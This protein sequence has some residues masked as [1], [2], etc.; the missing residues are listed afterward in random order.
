MPL[1][2]PLRLSDYICTSGLSVWKDK[3]C[4][5]F[6]FHAYSLGTAPANPSLICKN[7]FCSFYASPKRVT[8]PKPAPPSL[9]RYHVHP[10]TICK[11][12]LSGSEFYSEIQVR[13]PPH[14]PRLPHRQ[15]E[16]SAPPLHR[17]QN[18]PEIPKQIRNSLGRACGSSPRNTQVLCRSIIAR[19]GI[20][21]P[22]PRPRFLAEIRQEKR[23]NGKSRDMRVLFSCSG[24]VFYP[25]SIA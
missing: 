20:Q 7:C 3:S 23:R 14:S 12:P 16:S 25:F 15:A 24:K 18:M 9:H 6:S 2:V 4:E 1:H 22:P 10:D 21:P 13:H 11:P 17:Q 8:Y 19:N 5:F